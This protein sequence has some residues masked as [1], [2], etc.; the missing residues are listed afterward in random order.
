M[1]LRPTDRDGEIL[2]IV[3]ACLDLDAAAR[4]TLITERCG[5]NAGLRRRVERLLTVDD[6]LQS[7][8]LTM[9]GA[10][11]LTPDPVPER[12]GPYR[13]TAILG[14]GGM[15]TVLRG[16]RDDGLYSRTVAIKLIRAGLKDDRARAMFAQERRLLARLSHPSITQIIDGGTIDDRPYLIMDHVDGRPV[17]DALAARKAGLADR[18]DCFLA[19]CAAISHA[20]RALIVHADIKPSNVMIDQDGRVRLLDFGIARLVQELEPEQ[21]DGIHPL[22]PGYAAPERVAGQAPTIAGDVYG[23]GALLHEMLTGQLPDRKGAAMS[24]CAAAAQAGAPFPADM[25]RGDLDAI[26]ARALATDPAAR[27]PDVGALAD[28]LQRY[29][30]HKPVAAREGGFTYR[31]GRFLRRNRLPVMIA[32]LVFAVLTAATVISVRASIEARRERVAADTRFEQIRDLARY[33]LFTLYDELAGVPG[34]LPARIRL[35]G[36]AQAYLDALARSPGAPDPIRL[37][38]AA[39]YVRLAQIQGDPRRPN[40]GN[41]VE[42][43]RNL[44][45]ARALLLPLRSRH[46]ADSAV[47]LRLAETHVAIANMAIWQDRDLAAGERELKQAAALFASP[48]PGDIGWIEAEAAYR[49]AESDLMGWAARFTE[50][51]RSAANTAAWFRT[52]PSPAASRPAMIR[53]RA[54]AIAAVAEAN[55]YQGRQDKAL[56]LYREADAL[57]EAALAGAPHDMELL[58]TRIFTGYQLAGTLGEMNLLTGLAER[59]RALLAEANRLAL[60]EPAD[61]QIDVR[62][63]MIANLLAQI[64]SEEGRYGEAAKI[65]S[66]VLARIYDREGNGTASAKSQRDFAYN[67]KILGSI[68][69]KN[70]E[71]QRACLLWRTARRRLADLESDGRLSALDQTNI[72]FI[73]ELERMMQPC[74]PA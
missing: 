28:D 74:P 64:L 6:R 50:Q 5:D 70:G 22:T 42:A 25:L 35:T 67:E 2:A 30:R 52:L 21:A 4:T 57:V 56:T 11:D 65:Q 1:S 43:R 26:A 61:R 46:P 51:E 69:W 58:N 17:T 54:I 68:L 19:I 40:S 49:N 32:T 59:L 44:T 34:T 31:A 29:L 55:Y 63:D 10:L 41:F 36:K 3:E 23:L 62:V 71:T 14:R 15:A 27:Y 24:Q 38:T 60:L 45:A 47:A 13:I 16:E 18:L 66:H 20:H 37:D 9:I 12:I 48:H 8:P 7:S 53:A 73:P 33:Q 72:R 39:G